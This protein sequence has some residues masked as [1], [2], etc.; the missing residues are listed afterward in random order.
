MDHKFDFGQKQDTQIVYVRPVAAS[1]LPEELRAHANGQT[2]LYAVHDNNGQRLAVVSDRK[3]AF[4]LAR[5]HDLSP[6]NVH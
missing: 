1:D 3:M 2:N 6:V 5:Q 4:A